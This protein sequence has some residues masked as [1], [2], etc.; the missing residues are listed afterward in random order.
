MLG[1]IGGLQPCRHANSGCVAGNRGTQLIEL[2]LRESCH[3][4]QVLQIKLLK[5]II[6]N[7]RATLLGTVAFAPPPLHGDTD[8]ARCWHTNP[9]ERARSAV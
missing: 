9:L 4:F 8:F 2:E 5:V 3:S 1:S 6:V 7:R